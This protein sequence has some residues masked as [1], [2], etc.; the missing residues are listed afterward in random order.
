MRKIYISDCDIPCQKPLSK[1]WEENQTEFESCQTPLISLLFKQFR[2]TVAK[3]AWYYLISIFGD[4]SYLCVAKN[5]VAVA[6]NTV[7]VLWWEQ[8]YTMKYSLSTREIPRGF[9]RAQDFFIVFA[10]SSNTTDILNYNSSIDL[11]G[12]SVLKELILRIDLSTG[13]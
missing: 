9:S 12:R 13:Q 8:G 11:P 7:S 6:K 3:H 1:N 5:I 2:G 10:D 4:T